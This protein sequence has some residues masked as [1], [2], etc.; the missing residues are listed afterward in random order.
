MEFARGAGGGSEGGI[1]S[2]ARWWI[3]DPRERNRP[4]RTKRARAEKKTIGWPVLEGR[5]KMVR[6]SYTLPCGV[7]HKFHQ[8]C[9]DFPHVRRA[10]NSVGHRRV[11]MAPGRNGHSHESVGR[12]WVQEITGRR[13]C[14]T[15]TG[16]PLDQ[17]SRAIDAGPP[18]PP[19]P[20]TASSLAS[21]RRRRA[22]KKHH[23]ANLGSVA[24][25]P[26]H[27]RHQG[28]RGGE[29]YRNRMRHP[30]CSDVYQTS[31]NRSGGNQ[32]RLVLSK[33]CS[34]IRKSWILDEPTRGIDTAPRTRIYCITRGGRRRQGRVS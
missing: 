33:W 7:G 26:R 28:L 1:A 6:S 9:S 10:R 30:L 5:R 8:E 15:A 25:G 19:S 2:S 12:S 18:W 21:P 3:R 4:S 17:V 11:L 20:K 23:A 14:C 27:R 29:R 32:Q 24:T 22:L 16:R 13:H 31:C 34:P